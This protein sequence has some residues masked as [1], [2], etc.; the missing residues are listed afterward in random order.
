VSLNQ[1]EDAEATIE[2]RRPR[3]GDEKVGRVG[4]VGRVGRVGQ[5]RRVEVESGNVNHFSSVRRRSSPRECLV[6]RGSAA[7]LW[8]GLLEYGAALELQERT[9]AKRQSDDAAPDTWLIGEHPTVVTR[10]AR[11]KSE[12][13]PPAGLPVFEIDRGG[14][15]AMHGP[16]QLMIYPIARV[17]G[18]AMA[19]GRLARALL[20]ATRD[21]VREEFGIESAPEPGR[22]GLFVEGRKL[23]SLGLS[24]RRGVSMHGVALNLCND[25]ETWSAIAPCGDPTTRGVTL[26]EL[27]GRTVA[28]S[29]QVESIA[30]WLGG[31]WGYEKVE[32]RRL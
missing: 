15:S 7:L 3:R 18:G 31:A 21:W 6:D 19:A 26:S 2:L 27:V 10:G 5:H 17:A 8:F 28:P 23:M 22:P 4:Q 13:P 25:V 20:E 30:E 24:V 16:G 29:E 1:G 32:L 9:R 12:A 14:M 11:S